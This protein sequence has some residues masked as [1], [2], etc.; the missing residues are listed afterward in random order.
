MKGLLGAFLLLSFFCSAD[1]SGKVIRIIDGDTIEILNDNDIPVRVR[2]WGIDAPEKKQAYGS[3]ATTY[4][5]GLIAGK[6][7]L[8]KDRGEDIYKR[9]LGIVIYNNQDINKIMVQNGFAWAYD[10]KGKYVSLE[11]QRL[12]EI[13][14]YKQL[15]LWQDKNPIKPYDFRKN[16]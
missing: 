15:G 16:K 7:V 6:R 5:K 4:L 14:K 13:A 9:T 2:L 11:Y 10:H 8:I 12:Q 3:K 1:F